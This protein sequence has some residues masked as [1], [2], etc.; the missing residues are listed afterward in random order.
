M[1]SAGRDSS[2]CPLRWAFNFKVGEAILDDEVPDANE[3]LPPLMFA[4]ELLQAMNTIERGA[5]DE[6]PRTHP[7][8]AS[9]SAFE[10]GLSDHSTR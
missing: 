6:A 7:K 10:S 3:V 4:F 1:V 5:E 9:E 2:R 8:T